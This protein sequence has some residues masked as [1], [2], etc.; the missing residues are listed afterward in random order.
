MFSASQK[1]SALH[2]LPKVPEPLKSTTLHG[3]RDGTVSAEIA[4]VSPEFPRYQLNFMQEKSG[5]SHCKKGFKMT[6]SEPYFPQPN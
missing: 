2:P 4:R 1:S 6:K 5:F 3:C